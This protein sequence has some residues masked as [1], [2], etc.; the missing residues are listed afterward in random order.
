MDIRLRIG[1]R[2]I[3][4]YNTIRTFYN[5]GIIYD[6]GVLRKRQNKDLPTSFGA[7]GLTFFYGIIM[8]R[9]GTITSLYHTRHHSLKRNVNNH[10]ILR[11]SEI[12]SNR[13]TT[14]RAY[15]GTE[16]HHHEALKKRKGKPSKIGNDGRYFIPKIVIM[17]DGIS[18]PV[19]SNTERTDRTWLQT[20]W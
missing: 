3:E 19:R 16:R 15:N 2:Y 17:P 11:T 7:N 14:V 13:I 12:V 20:R 18:R 10:H 5:G 9:D 4:R 1:K 6:S 8:S